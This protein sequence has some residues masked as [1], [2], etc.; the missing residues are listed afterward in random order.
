MEMRGNYEPDEDDECLNYEDECDDDMMLEAPDAEEPL[1]VEQPAK[2]VKRTLFSLPEDPQERVEYFLQNLDKQEQRCHDLVHLLTSYATHLKLWLEQ[3]ELHSVDAHAM[4]MRWQRRAKNDLLSSTAYYMRWASYVSFHLPVQ[5]K[6][7]Q[8][9]ETRR[10][11]EVI[12]AAWKLVV[13]SPLITAKLDRRLIPNFTKIALAVLYAMRSG[14]YLLDCS[15]PEFVQLRDFAVMLLPKGEH[16]AQRLLDVQL[17]EKVSKQVKNIP[18]R[19]T[20][21]PTGTRLLK[22]SCTSWVELYQ[23]QLRESLASGVGEAVALRLYQRKCLQLRCR[24]LKN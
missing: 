5:P 9:I 18:L 22:E 11:V 19:K 15:M 3:M 20:Q 23:R 4:I 6:F 7:Y 10:Y 24:A 17:L 2:R 12:S 16:L 14:G 21:V 8:D 1:A 13:S